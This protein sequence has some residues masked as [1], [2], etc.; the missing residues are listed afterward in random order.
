MPKFFAVA[1]PLYLIMM[2]CKKFIKSSAHLSRHSNNHCAVVTFNLSLNFCTILHATFFVIQYNSLLFGIPSGN[3][4]HAKFS[5][6]VVLSRP[7][8]SDSSCSYLKTNSSRSRIIRKS[9]RF[10]DYTITYLRR[11]IINM[12]SLVILYYVLLSHTYFLL[13][14][15]TE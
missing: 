7:L 6:A 1:S 9:C 4:R 15:H 8:A 2:W 12:P 11:Y 3:F 5:V 14:S 10:K 13:N